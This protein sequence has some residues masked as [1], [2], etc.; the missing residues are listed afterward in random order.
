M[1]NGFKIK[2][3]EQAD[4][5]IIMEIY[6]KVNGSK[7]KDMELECFLCLK[8]KDIKVERNIKIRLPFLLASIPE[9]PKN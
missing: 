8:E 7:V 1:E 3:R 2:E 5:I 6:I 9:G 4:V